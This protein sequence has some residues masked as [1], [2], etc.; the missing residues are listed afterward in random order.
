[1]DETVEVEAYCLDTDGYPLKQANVLLQIEL[2]DGKTQ[3]IL[4][5]PVQ[6]GQYGIYRTRFTPS[7]PGEYRMR[8]IID[9]Y[10]GQP[11]ATSV[12]LTATRLNREKTSLWQDR[13]SLKAIATAGGGEYVEI[14]RVDTLPDLLDEKIDKQFLIAEYSPFRQWPYYLALAVTLGATWL[15]RK[16][17][18]LA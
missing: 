14:D 15:I 6:G 4:M 1:M 11:L 8:P 5:Q 13:V 18:G 2:K 10:G 17:S 9:K 7:R 3:R 12:S 16:R